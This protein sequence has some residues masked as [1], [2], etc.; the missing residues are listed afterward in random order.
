M[1]SPAPPGPAASAA[2]G[3]EPGGT[4]GGREVVELEVDGH[5]ERVIDGPGQS[6][7]AGRRRADARWGRCRRPPSSVRSRGPDARCAR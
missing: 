5:Q 3:R 7:T 6:D 1:R 4:S 2:S